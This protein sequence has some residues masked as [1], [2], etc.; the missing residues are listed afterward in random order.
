MLLRL[1]P[2]SLLEVWRAVP[3]WTGI[4]VSS[5][6][7]V[8][9]WKSKG[10]GPLRDAP[11]LRKLLPDRKGY[12]CVMLSRSRDDRKLAK[13]AQLVLIAFGRPR[14]EAGEVRHLNGVLDDNRLE[15]LTWGS[16]AENAEDRQ[17]HGTQLRGSGIA[18]SK[19]TESMVRIARLE[20]GT[21]TEKAQ[22]YGVSVST[23]RSALARKTWR[24]V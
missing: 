18:S 3:G 16:S 19:L 15:N 12:L 6:G 23:M 4:D 2:A 11:S 20:E 10:G 8:R 22:R 5:L 21:P 9:S 14:P 1:S 13:V 17:H 7:R 24:H